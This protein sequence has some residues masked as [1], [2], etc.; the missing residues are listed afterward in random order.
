MTWNNAMYFFFLRY[1][2]L[3]DLPRFLS[4]ITPPLNPLPKAT[5]SA[6]F[7]MVQGTPRRILALGWRWARAALP[8]A[9]NMLTATLRRLKRGSTKLAR[10]S[11]FSRNQR[12]P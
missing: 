5:N 4:F 6:P 9:R 2:F 8:A 12:H 3:E 1:K 10:V 7:L 11:G